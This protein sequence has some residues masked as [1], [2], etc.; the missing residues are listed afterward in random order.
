MSVRSN[1]TN[2]YA[3]Y[4]CSFTCYRWISLFEITQSYDCVY[5]WF[6]YLK[7]KN[8]DI[9]AY[10]I[11]PNHLHCILYFRE[12]QFNLNTIISN[13]KRFMAYEI[14]KR[15]E[16]S[17]INL[18]S[19]LA[20]AVTSRESKKGQKHKVFEDSFDAKAVFNKPFLTQK[21][22]YIHSNPIK[23]KWKLA[24]DFTRYEHSSASFY[25]TGVSVHFKP[26]HYID[27]GL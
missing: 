8:I 7:S 18:L 6:E 13:A 17:D 27:I 19:Q 15:L 16:R 12:H 26:V 11:M 23:G 5:N 25:E 10:V 20:D 14:I 3:T 1:H 4:F 2:V 21:I 9:I 24:D 22:N